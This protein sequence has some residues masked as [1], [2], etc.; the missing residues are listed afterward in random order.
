MRLFTAIAL[1]FSFVSFVGC[2]SQSVENGS[3][4]SAEISKASFN[5]EGAPT[6]AF[7]VPGMH[8]SS[9]AGAICETLEEVPGVVD[10]ETD[11]S[12]KIATVA[13]DKET[14]DSAAA[15]AALSDADFTKASLMATAVET[16]SDPLIVVEEEPTVDSVEAADSEE[17]S[18][19][20][21]E[22]ASDSE[23]E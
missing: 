10:I 18:D 13:I 11:V 5:T 14:F 21:S 23:E 8:C 20:I 6:I 12:T 7:N 3:E 1:A 2:G 15:I 19:S 16:V 9:C 4:V 22:E 17:A